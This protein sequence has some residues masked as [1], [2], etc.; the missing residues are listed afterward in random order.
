MDDVKK[1]ATMSTGMKI[2]NDNMP[3]VCKGC[4]D[5]KHARAVSHTP[6]TRASA[7]VDL[8]HVDLMG[9]ITPTAYNGHQ[10]TLILT[11]DYSQVSILRMMRSKEEVKKN[12]VDVYTLLEVQTGQ[13]IKQY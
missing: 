6:G 7:A 13:K 9:P 2:K 4:V 10:Y 1:L 8:V 12:M 5:G 11:N 3:D